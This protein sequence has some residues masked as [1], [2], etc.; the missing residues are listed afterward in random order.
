MTTTLARVPFQTAFVIRGIAPACPAIGKGPGAPSAG[1]LDR[2]YRRRLLELG[3]LEGAT[4]RV[5]GAAPMGDPLDVEL[6]GC[7]Y[8]LRRAEA[9]AILVVPL[10]A[11]AAPPLEL[12][13]K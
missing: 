12:A 2:G 11:V 4:V 3:F 13:A 6:R 7:R 9:E 10:A 8:S 5:I 1:G